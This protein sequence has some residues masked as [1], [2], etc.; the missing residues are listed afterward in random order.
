MRCIYIIQIILIFEL[1]GTTVESTLSVFLELTTLAGFP[2]DTVD[3]PIVIMKMN[4]I[5][6]VYHR[7]FGTRRSVYMVEETRY[8]R[9]G[10]SELHVWIIYER[11]PQLQSKTGS[12]RIAYLVENLAC[13]R[14]E[15]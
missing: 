5:F 2:L 7:G 11:L 1:P 3:V 14:E 9:V 15:H 6:K 12:A 13:R 10:D 4:S 8:C